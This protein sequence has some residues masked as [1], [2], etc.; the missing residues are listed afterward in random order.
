ME[1]A[2]VAL[3]ILLSIA[4]QVVAFEYATASIER[5]IYKY[6]RS[7]GEYADAEAIRQ[8]A[9]ASVARTARL[10]AKLVSISETVSEDSLIDS[11]TLTRKLVPTRT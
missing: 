1:C 4:M 2:I 9:D 6:V 10:A 11:S 7:A 8:S 3:P 5:E